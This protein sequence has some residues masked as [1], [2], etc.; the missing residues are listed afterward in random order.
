M[1]RLIDVPAPVGRPLQG[2]SDALRANLRG[3]LVPVVVAYAL[4]ECRRNAVQ[5]WRRLTLRTH[6][7]RLHHFLLGATW[8]AR[9]ILHGYVRDVL[10]QMKPGPRETLYLIL[11]ETRLAKRGKQVA[12][13][14]WYFD[15]VTR[16]KQRAQLVLVATVWFRGFIFPWDFFV[17][18]KRGTVPSAEFEKLTDA[19]ARMVREF[20]P[21]PAVRVVVLFD[22][23]YLCKTVAGAVRERGWLYVSQAKENRNVFVARRKS[24]AGRR[25]KRALRNGRG[26][27]VRLGQHRYRFVQEDADMKGLG[28]VRLVYSRPIARRG[29]RK[30]FVSN[31]V[32][33]SGE[34]ILWHYYRR[35][36][37]E[38]FIK[39]SK[40]TLGLGDCS[41]SRS[42]AAVTHL[43]LVG[44]AAALLTHR[45]VRARGAQ[46]KKAQGDLFA[47][48]SLRT[49][50]ETL[51]QE[52]IAYHLHRILAAPT[53]RKAKQILRSWTEL[54]VA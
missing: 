23:Y 3:Y 26:R 41:S 24:K 5:L 34:T 1:F 10:M 53:S 35:W 17:H 12:R 19:A 7:T 21:P 39:E 25:A 43:L 52:V 27:K 46:G 33:H 16:R 4:A 42:D 9:D 14:D 49:L 20:V 47:R 30:I 6:R 29:K 32:S 37:I 2:Y 54:E 48:S 22:S 40:Q 44:L 13:A 36:S 51:R 38:V 15:P 45:D 18:A 31:D 50:Q 11:D 28:R 8:P